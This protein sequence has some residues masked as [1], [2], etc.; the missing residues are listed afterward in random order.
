MKRI[1][2]LFSTLIVLVILSIF[3][4][5]DNNNQWYYAP[6]IPPITVDGDLSDWPSYVASSAVSWVW[7]SGNPPD[8]PADFTG[9]FRAAFN[10]A[11][12]KL[13]VAVE[14]TDQDIVDS[15][16]WI[17][18]EGDYVE[19]YIDGDHVHQTPGQ[20][21]EFQQYG[22]RPS[23]DCI[24][25]PTTTVPAKDIT[26][27][28]HSTSNKYTYEI[29]LTVYDK[30]VSEIV[31]TF[32]GGQTIGFDMSL[33]DKDNTDGSFSWIAWTPQG[34]KWN[35]SNLF[36][37]MLM[38]AIDVSP[39]AVIL[40]PGE[41]VD[42]VATGGTAPYSWISSDT[43]VGTITVINDTT[44]RFTANSV[45][46]ALIKAKDANNLENATPATVQVVTTEAP[47]A[48]QTPQVIIYQRDWFPAE[49]I[50]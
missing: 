2:Y 14:Y 27:A 17:W 6:E 32:Y 28:I 21:E 40:R 41:T 1:L 31:H 24:V 11:E 18:N 22:I 33:P 47:L 4:F 23:G 39:T 3:A 5:A 30:Y 16:N 46:T 12:N 15:G 19:M 10:R 7:P 38:I 20:P 35:N 48:V 44:G 25:Y 8:N 9:S 29:A 45:G 36:G 43:T 26:I 13:Y 49:L 37:N 50:E 34:G 42:F